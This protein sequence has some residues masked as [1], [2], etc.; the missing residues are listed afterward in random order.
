MANRYPFHAPPGIRYSVCAIVL[1]VSAA[2]VYTL[3]PRFISQVYYLKARNQHK[4]GY[5]GLAVINYKNAGSYQPRD[6]TIWKKLADAQLSMGTKKLPRQA[7]HNT[8]KAKASYLRALRYNPLDAE[9]AY[10]LAKTEGRLEWLYDHL[11]QKNKNNPYH[12]LPYF[13]KA[14]HLRPNGISCHYSMARYLYRQNNV[15]AII[16]VVRSLA[17]MYPP[18]YANLKKEPLWSPCIKKAVKQGILDSIHRGRQLE[19]A[20]K[21]MSSILAEDKDW[22]DAIVHFQKLIECKK[23]KISTQ[24]YIHLGSLYLQN[25]Q[26]HEANINFIRSLYLSMPVEKA[27]R[28]IIHIFKNKNHGDD[29]YTFYQEVKHRFTFSPQMHLISARYFIDSKQYKR[30]RHILTEVNRQEPTAEAYY[31]LARM[32]E[33]QKDWDQVELNIQKA[34]VLEP[35]NLNYRRMFYGVLKRLGKHETAEKQ[36]GLM[37]QNSESPSLRLFDERAKC[38]LKQKDFLGAVTDWK[39]A[40]ALAPQNAPFHANIAEAYMKLGD[41]PRTLEHYE[42]AIALNPGN[43]GYVKRYTTLIESKLD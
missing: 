1:C 23:D 22:P 18:V 21:A 35:S 16:P 36:I 24:D 28:A 4:N 25:E 32:A 9:T 12:A 10:C 20:H 5:F 29:F 13:E 40:I 34:T 3:Y 14:I 42:K 43:H 38:R 7:F 6:A 41:L 17:G 37:I 30:A 15:K 31:W 19:S 26:I 27:F 11:R 39:A 8:Q 2:A 33:K